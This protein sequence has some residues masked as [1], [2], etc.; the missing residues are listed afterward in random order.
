M[1]YYKI[2]IEERS[3]T[4]FMKAIPAFYL[5]IGMTLPSLLLVLFEI[6]N[7]LCNLYIKFGISG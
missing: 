2:R 7:F 4:L 3:F 5:I 1:L 6:L